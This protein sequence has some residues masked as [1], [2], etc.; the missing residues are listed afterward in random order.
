MKKSQF[1]CFKRKDKLF[2]L[3]QEESTFFFGDKEQMN[4]IE[5]SHVEKV[6]EFVANS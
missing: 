6:K 2:Y 3:I 1:V 5:S 4:Q